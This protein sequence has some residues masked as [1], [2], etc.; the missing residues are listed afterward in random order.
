M[1]AKRAIRTCLLTSAVLIGATTA[2]VAQSP[3]PASPSARPS[4]PSSGS[5]AAD[6]VISNRVIGTGTYPGYTLEVPEGWSTEGKF[7]LRP[8]GGPLGISVWDVGEVPG[9]PCHWQ[10]SSRHPGPTVDD[11]VAALRAQASREA[12]EPVDVTLAGYP[13]RYLEWSVPTDLVVTG[14]ADFQ[15]CD[16]MEEHFDFVSWFGNGEGER[17][18]QL[19]G[20]VDRLWVLD[21]DGQRLLV[22]ATHPADATPAVLA[23]Q[24]AIVQSLRFQQP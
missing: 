11:L 10:A 24:D 17:Y 7:T 22:D 16:A 15:G 4:A 13:G 20:Q 2:T 9:D 14:D 1:H 6:T 5:P 8:Q 3:S 18:Q 19:A 12:T 23:E 21:V